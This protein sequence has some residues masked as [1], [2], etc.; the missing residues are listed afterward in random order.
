MAYLMTPACIR[1]PAFIYVQLC[2]HLACNGGLAFIRGRRLL[3]EIHYMCCKC[4][5]NRDT[6]LA[7]FGLGLNDTN[8]LKW[9]IHVI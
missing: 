6:H 2:S 4:K 9:W 7:L 5:L 1:D 3:Q 8:L